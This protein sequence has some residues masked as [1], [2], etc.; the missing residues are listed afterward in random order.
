MLIP[1]VVQATESFNPSI[2]SNGLG[3]F[4]LAQAAR[5]EGIKIILGGEGADELFG[6]TILSTQR[7][8]REVP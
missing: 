5:K 7:P 8:I 2:V 1:A 6:D 3:T 4:L